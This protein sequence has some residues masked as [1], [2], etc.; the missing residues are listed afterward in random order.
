MKS[1]LRDDA[2]EL[3]PEYDLTQLQLRRPSHPWWL[4]P[5][6]TAVDAP[7][8]WWLK[9]AGL[10]EDR[11]RSG[12][13]GSSLRSGYFGDKRPVYAAAVR[14]LAGLERREPGGGYGARSLGLVQRAK[15]REL[16]DSLKGGSQAES[17]GP[18]G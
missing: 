3:H 4:A 15:V 5:V 7:G 11:P 16:L 12:I 8:A 18:G 10:S 1:T 13:S 2:D 17:V 6:A 9:A 14:V